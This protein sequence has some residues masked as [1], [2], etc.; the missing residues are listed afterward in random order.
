[1]AAEELTVELFQH[2]RWV[3]LATLTFNEPN[4]G[5]KGPCRM[6][7]RF[8]HTITHYL[9][10]ADSAVSILLPV[11]TYVETYVEQSMHWYRFLE[12]I[13]PAGSSRDFWVNRLGLQDA[14]EPQ[15]DFRL[16]QQGTIAPIGNL[17]IKESLNQGAE[18]EMIAQMRFPI[19]DVTERHSDFLEYAQARG[20][21]AGGAS[22]AGGAA[23]KLLLRCNKDDQVWIDAYQNQIDNT[24]Q[25]Y[26]VKFARGNTQRDADI[27]RAEFH[28]YHILTTLKFDTIDIST[29]RLIES[30]RGPS[31]WLP[32]FDVAINNGQ[33]EHRGLESVYS[34]LDKSSASFMYHS[35]VIRE[36]IRVIGQNCDAST[37]SSF[38]DSHGTAWFVIEWV[39]RD[40]LN[41]IFGNSDNHGRNTS[42]LKH[43][44][45]ISLAPVYDF[46]PMKADMEGITRTFT[47][48][49]K[50]TAHGVMEVGGEYNFNAIAQ[51]L[52]D[53][54]DPD[55]LLNELR[56][57]AGRL[58]NIETYLN[59]RGV[60]KSIV[61]HS[62]IGYGATANKLERWGL[63]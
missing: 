14:P 50:Q 22:G 47:W 59:E 57:L 30:E 48:G 58:V 56:E 62:G 38:L 15:R 9:E 40:L 37:T 33:V 17:R 28:F 34:V 61:E 26:L 23:P 21:A 46:A 45:V 35:D 27:L 60:P 7:Y 12:D 11:E 3:E 19:T 43:N 20:A 18:N 25:H 1:M 16:L 5:I 63:V 55:I 6:V 54:V 24:D 8:D 49:S 44:D 32:R 36:L 10:C 52:A 41:I 53:L 2:G 51:S 13:M 4:S 42:F 39:K 29:M 31:L